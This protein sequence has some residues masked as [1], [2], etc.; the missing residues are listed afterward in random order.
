LRGEAAIASAKVAYGIWKEIYAGR[1]FQ[2][3][4]AMGAL[5]QRLLWASTSTK[6]PAYSDVKYVE[7]LIGPDTVNTVP[8]E[9]LN[10]YRD[11]GKPALRLEE[12][13]DEARLCLARLAE[14]G[15]DLAA[16]TQKLED[17]GVEKFVKPFDKLL[18]TLEKKR[19]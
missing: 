16:V 14:A 9:T 6:D 12:G 18:E 8:L 5:P 4:A 1:R 2:R 11:H 17:E 3:L 13:I 7:A 10:A 15:I 19:S